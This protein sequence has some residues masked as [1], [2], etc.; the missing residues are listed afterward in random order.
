MARAAPNRGDNL[1][2]LTFDSDEDSERSA[3]P[4]HARAD[5]FNHLIDLSEEDPVTPIDLTELNN[6]PDYNAPPSPVQVPSEEVTPITETECLQNILNVFPDIAVDYVTDLVQNQEARTTSDCERLITKLLDDGTY[7]KERDEANQRK[8]KR[9]AN[10]E[11]DFTEFETGQHGVG[12][13]GYRQN[14]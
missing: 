14:A 13:A 1:I 8:R 2:D 4:L 7:P 6:I 9:G 11:Y 3:T 5:G 10:D 12:V